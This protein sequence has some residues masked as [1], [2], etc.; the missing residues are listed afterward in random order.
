MSGAPLVS[1]VVPTHSRRTWLQETLDSVRRQSFHDWEC[2]VVDDASDDD[3]WPWLQTLD[4]GRFRSF[5][6][7]TSQ[8]RSRARNRGLR[9]ARGRYVLFLDDDDLLPPDALQRHVEALQPSPR[10]FGSAGGA[11][12]FW[13]DGSRRRWKVMPRRLLRDVTLD[14]VF[15]WVPVSGQ[16][17]LSR[18]LLLQVGGWREDMSYAE[19]HELLLRLSRL[20]P[21]VIVPGVVHYYRCHDQWRPDG[22]SRLMDEVREQAIAALSEPLRSRCRHALEA[23]R[24]RDTA[25]QA[26]E[27]GRLLR[28]VR[29][30]GRM[31]R[32]SPRLFTSP[33]TRDDLLPPLLK[34]SLGWPLVHAGRAA[35]TWLKRSA[36]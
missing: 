1:V 23:R 5:R 22:F 11:E 35:R 24:L 25:E 12:L 28:A 29:L 15:G 30:Y 10:A 18:S 7:D 27:D 19:D 20:G 6:F 3:T 32:L 14:I 26:Y 36:H 17:L 9:E 31:L 33:L 16:W 8:E 21:A 34:A 13:P 2:L 4:D